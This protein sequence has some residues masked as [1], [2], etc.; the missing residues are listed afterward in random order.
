MS[1]TAVDV[2]SIVLTGNVPQIGLGVDAT[3]K[4]VAADGGVAIGVSAQT[5]IINDTI[6]VDHGP[7]CEALS[8]AAIDIATVTQVMWDATARL[9]PYTAAAGRRAA[10]TVARQQGAPITAAGQWVRFYPDNF[11]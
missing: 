11:V 6:R 8:G 9:V 7:I 10:G 5:G 1:K 2:S 3:G 4:L